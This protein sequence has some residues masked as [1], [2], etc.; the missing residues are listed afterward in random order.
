MPPRVRRFP[1]P[2]VGTLIRSVWPTGHLF[3]TVYSVVQY[4]RFQRRFPRM[5]RPLLLNDHLLKFRI[6]GTLL[7]PLRQFVTDKEYVKHYI[8]STVGREHTLETFDILRTPSDIDRFSLKRVPCVVKP[9]HMSGEVLFHREVD[10]EPDR[11]R[12]TKWLHSDYYRTSRES[13]YRYL[14]PKVIVEELFSED[15]LA[16]PRDFKIHCF[17]GTPLL[18]QVD[19]GRFENLTR[20]WYDPSW[21][22][23][24]MEW[25]YPQGAYDDKQPSEL[26]HMLDVATTLCSPFTYVR[27]DMYA[28]G[29]HV[30]VGEI[31][32]RPGGAYAVLRP[33]RMEA[34][35][36]ARLSERNGG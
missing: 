29:K 15:G 5:S 26:S 24:K 31:T 25:M 12:M 19:S 33:S 34:C 16:V 22:R 32:N 2:Y 14:E 17:Q 13:N 11:I 23:V 10:E 27:V 35:L 20:N 30:K 4:I 18:V 21:R 28:S 8:T 6:D 1:I 7:H 3:D 9:T 36:G